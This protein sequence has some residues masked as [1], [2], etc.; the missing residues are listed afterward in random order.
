VACQTKPYAKYWVIAAY[1][2]LLFF[3]SSWKASAQAYVLR[4]VTTDSGGI[5]FVGNTLGLAKLTQV[6]QPGALDSVGGFITL[7]TNSQLG[8]YPKGT[9]LNWSNNSSS[10]ILQLPTNSTVLYAELIWAGTAQINTTNPPGSTGNVLEYL[11]APVYFILPNGASNNI[12][13][14]PATASLVTNG[15]VTAPTA[16]FYVRSANVTALVQAAG[17]GTYSAG[18]VPA[19]VLAQEDANNACG[20]TLAVVYEDTALHQRNL[21]LFVGNSFASTTAT[22][23]AP[24]GVVGFC[25][26]PTGAINGYLF[27]SAIEGDPSKTGDEML[28]GPNTNSLAVLSGPNNIKTNFFAS[29]INYADPDSPSNGL[30]NT[31]GTF[32]LSNS[33]PPTVGFS[34]RQGWDITSVNVSSGLTNGIESA[35]A[36]NITSGDGYSVNA[37]ALQIDVGSPV[38]T[39][40]QSVDKASTFVGDTLTYTVVVTNSGTANAVNLIFTDP[41][42]FGTSFITNTFAVNGVAA[43]GANPVNGVP[44]PIINEN[45]NITFSYQVNLS[46]TRQSTINIP[47]RARKAR[48][49]TVRW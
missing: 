11:S 46:R 23:P 29:Q 2:L 47:A 48:S 30:L 15:T 33:V 22:T 45:S 42:P 18:G 12:T 20:W 35:Y 38:L 49:S 31:T 24:I 27:V 25:S 37:L 9:T 6:N 17:P 28:F 34:A 21:S 16:E 13:P 43:P 41:L 7:N 26:P 36:Q 40:T 1:S 8:T 32:G 39:T 4:Y 44:V 5:T 3:G 19:C 10:A 14:D